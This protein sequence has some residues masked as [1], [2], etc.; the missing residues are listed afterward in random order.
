MQSTS[1]ALGVVLTSSCNLRC[2]YCYQNAKAPGRMEWETLRKAVDR[3]LDSGASRLELLFLGGEPLLELGLIRRAV[4][5]VEARAS[6]RQEISFWVSTN[7]TLLDGEAADFFV[8]HRFALQLSFDGVAAA[9]ELRGMGTFAT[10]DRRIGGL[11]ERH[12]GYCRRH[13]AVS[14]TLVPGTIPHLASSV[15]YFL[16]R[17]VRILG[18]A[19]DLTLSPGW[20]E[21]AHTELE[22]QF[23]RVCSLSVR[24]WI[25]TGAVPLS[26]LRAE[27]RARSP[28]AGRGLPM[29]SVGAGGVL[30]VDVDGTVCPCPLLAHSYLD[31]GTDFLRRRLTP[32]RLGRL[33]SSELEERLAALPEAV[34]KAEIFDH[35]ERK[36][37]SYGRCA[38]CPHLGSCAICPISIGRIP[39]NR[40]PHRVP[41]FLCAFNRLA[42]ECRDRF[43]SECGLRGTV[44]AVDPLEA[45]VDS[46]RDDWL[47]E[48]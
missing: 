44:P 43:R 8:A 2:A 29:C 12:P 14:M 35:K 33:D 42:A 39:G 45:L 47:R 41:D 18:L 38:D 21:A 25:C 13:L 28:D 9:Q 6:P 24:H 31:H 11:L 23:R 48:C 16:S 22:E 26:L 30:L 40:D 20:D 7:G 36:Y 17:G 19:P 46:E 3:L 4:A 37:S 27:P 10:L 5:H 15:R 32:L 34:R 1:N